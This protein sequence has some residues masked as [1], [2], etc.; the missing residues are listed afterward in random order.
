MS[1]FSERRVE[2]RRRRRRNKVGANRAKVEIFRNHVEAVSGRVYE[3]LSFCR[4]TVETLSGMFEA[5][6]KRGREQGEAVSKRC[7]REG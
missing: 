3:N 6:S 4:K 7:R 5:R 1:K 2:I